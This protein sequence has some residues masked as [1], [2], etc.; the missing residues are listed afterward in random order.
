MTRAVIAIMAIVVVGAISVWGLQAATANA[1]EETQISDESFTPDAGAVTQ[2]QHSNLSNTY[3]GD[4]VTVRDSGGT[5][6]DAGE[7]YIWNE[8]NGTIK[9]VSGGAL[10]GD[11]SAT[12]DYDYQRTTEDQRALIGIAAM[13]PRLLGVLVP[14]LG[15]ALLLIFLGG[16]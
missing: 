10:D 11:S 9:T 16:N 4:S 14:V 12:I 15:V 1:G 8:G 2:L 13:L 6:V 3:Y 5:I 7:D